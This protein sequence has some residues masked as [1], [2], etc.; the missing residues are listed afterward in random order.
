MKQRLNER[1]PAI[2]LKKSSGQQKPGRLAA[3]AHFTQR[4]LH[5]LG[6]NIYGFVFEAVISPIVMLL[7]FTF[8]FGGAIAGSAGEYVQF[9]LPGILVLTVVPMTVTS[10][11]TLCTDMA[12]G[13]YQRFRTMPFWQPAAVFGLVAAD[14]LRYAAGLAAVLGAGWALGFRPAAGVPG[15]AL[16]AAYIIFFAYCVSWVFTWVGSIARR[17]ETVSG[18]SMMILYPLLFASSVLVDTATMPRWLRAAVDA[19]PI[20]AAASL[21]RGLF[22]GTATAGELAAGIGAGLLIAAVFIP[23]TMYAYLRKQ[24]G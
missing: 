7:I 5:H 17:P 13:V 11:T 21:T 6:N 3:A 24:P 23:L 2:L 16:A 10:G 15:A 12:R 9:L 1:R 18:S 19:N 20:S 8:L 14:G 4:S 22:H